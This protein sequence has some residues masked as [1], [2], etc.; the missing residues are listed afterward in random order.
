M[1]RDAQ[2]HAVTG[3]TAE[4]VELYDKAV[5]AFTLSYGDT[6]GLFEAAR[7][8]APG[9]VMAHLGKAWVLAGANDAVLVKGAG[10]LL[11]AARALPMNER[12]RAHLVALEHA[13]QG[14]REAAIAVL[15]PLLMHHPRDLLAHFS[16]MIASAFSGRFHTVRD[17][18]ARAL[19]FWSG[20]DP[21]YG[22]MLSFY[23]FGL[24]EA[25]DYEKAE[26]VSREAARLEP[27]GYWPHHAVSHV[28]EMTG[29]PA[30]GLKWMTDREPLWSGK[31]NGSR[32]HVWWHK[33]LFHV[34]LGEYDAAMAIYDGPIVETQRPA[35]I[36]LTNASALLWRLEA[37]GYD[38][39]ERWK[40]L[41]AL[42]RGH[43]DG[44]LSL[45]ADIHAVMA[46]LR[47][48]DGSELDCLV[49]SMQATA[50]SD[51]EVGGTY[52]DI[53]LPLVAG[54]TAF[55]R[56]AY[57]AAVEGLLASRY[58]LWRLGGSHAQRDVVDWTLTEAATRAGMKDVALSL[59]HER[60]ALRPG[61]APNRRFLAAAEAIPG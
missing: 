22:I 16:A 24:E 54:L 10:P 34:E 23:G 1:L 32:T 7:R 4:A 48:G 52:R 14:H 17:R 27:Y 19:P 47:A 12:E 8:A 25:G 43:A 29:R 39:G 37:L 45:F 30:D 35:G 53:G 57:A 46:A 13:V 20:S 9:F 33:A 61:S 36:V 21:S 58:H 40:A 44:R 15:D 59:A 3:A 6:I 38:G 11:E 31:D 5:R 26:D 51:P 41:A 28:L 50:D 55:N 60:L 56:G 49:A 18:S 2:G 42:W